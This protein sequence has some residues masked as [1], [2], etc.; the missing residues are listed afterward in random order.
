MVSPEQP[1]GPGNEPGV[2]IRRALCELTVSPAETKNLTIMKTNH[3]IKSAL[4]A[5]LLGLGAQPAV[6]GLKINLVNLGGE[7]PTAPTMVGG[8][9]LPA[10]MEVAAK[11]WERALNKGGS[12]WEVT[13][14]YI[15]G[16][17]GAAYGQEKMVEQGGKPVRITRSRITFRNT[18][19]TNT[20]IFNWYADPTPKNNS[21]FKV[22]NSTL[23]EIED[24]DFNPLGELNVGRVLTGATG[25]AVGRVDLL[26]VA[27][28]EIGHALGFDGEYVGHSNQI[29]GTFIT[30]TAP[31]PFPGFFVALSAGFADHLWAFAPLP[32]MV[33]DPEPGERQLISGI[34][35]L[36]IS[37]FS[38]F[39]RPDLGEPPG[40]PK[41]HNEP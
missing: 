35:A 23:A 41:V 36:V 26:T 6:A 16:L 34:D 2:S 24:L 17:P 18:V 15:W 4:L 25:L 31:R 33:Y 20:N 32:L 12:K 10:I 29:S 19:V 21:E 39:D 11:D 9:N 27:T 3:V 30:I 14:E 7:P 37:Q 5:C 13:I 38:S 28:H 8:G 1:T 40:V 22:Y